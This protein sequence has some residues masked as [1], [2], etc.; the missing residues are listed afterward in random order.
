MEGLNVFFA[1]AAA[2]II[3]GASCLLYVLL[4]QNR[5]LVVGRFILSLI[6]GGFGFAT[7]YLSANEEMTQ[8]VEAGIVVLCFT[9]G[10]QCYISISQVG[11]CK[12]LLAN[13]AVFAGL[14]F[15]AVW[16]VLTLPGSTLVGLVIPAIVGTICI[17]IALIDFFVYHKKGQ[18]LADPSTISSSSR[19]GYLAAL[20]AT[21]VLGVALVV[22]M[23]VVAA[24][25]PVNADDKGVVTIPTPKTTSDDGS[26]KDYVDVI[27]Y[28]SLL[29]NDGDSTNDYNFGTAG[30]INSVDATKKEFWFRMKHDPG[31]AATQ[32][33]REDSKCGTHFLDEYYTS[34][35][36]DVE[37]AINTAAAAFEGDSALWE[38]K[39]VAYAKHCKKTTAGYSIGTENVWQSQAFMD[40]H[41]LSSTGRPR[42]IAMK[43]A[44]GPSHLFIQRR[45]I[46]GKVIDVVTRIECGYQPLDVE[47]DG[48]KVTN[49]SGGDDNPNP[50][51]PTPEQ[52]TEPSGP[53]YNK[54]PNVAP[55]KNTEPND[56]KGP[57]PDTNNGKGAQYSKKDQPDNSNKMSQSEYNANVNKIKDINNTQQKAGDPNTPSTRKPSADTNV[58]NNGNKGTG[59]GGADTPTPTKSPAKQEDGTEINTKPAGQ[60]DGDPG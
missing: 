53:E 43:T 34:C 8:F 13:L 60:W 57:G 4:D 46:D 52:E 54:D 21:A 31:Y 7:I 58:D 23:I 3:F 50:P 16:S 49:P 25:Q 41:N 51:G 30:P 48:F 22:A 35:N 6:F 27:N 44:S 59:N 15:A 1:A 56:D 42:V 45:V 32:L 26:L 9:M 12:E 37:E 55:K 28:N 40:P 47:E 33:W 18:H 5:K 20:I 2:V 39:V 11:E 24:Q 17:G 14:I 19:T 10:Y 29:Q 38:K 36:G